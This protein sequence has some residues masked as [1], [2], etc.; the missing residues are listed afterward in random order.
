MLRDLDIELGCKFRQQLI[1][2]SDMVLVENG[3]GECKG[4]SERYF[5]V[6]LEKTKGNLQKGELVRVKLVEN[7][8]NG[9]I[10]QAE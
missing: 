2:T 9:V 4:R 1:G 5:M 10:G 3:N 6:Q 7:G 8:E